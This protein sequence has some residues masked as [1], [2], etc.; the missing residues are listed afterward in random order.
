MVF[1][2]VTLFFIVIFFQEKKYVSS[3]NYIYVFFFNFSCVF[4]RSSFQSTRHVQEIIIFSY[5]SNLSSPPHPN[6]LLYLIQPIFSPSS[7][8]SSLPYPTYLLHLIQP[9]LLYLIQPIFSLSSNLSSSTHPTYLIPLI[10][11][12]FSYSFNLSSPTHPTYLLLLI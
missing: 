2:F 10:Q 8:P 7:N 11:P 6:H 12:I 3:L 1:L 5:S 9:I 4:F